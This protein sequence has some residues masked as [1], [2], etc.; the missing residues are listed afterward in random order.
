VSLKWE[1][2]PIRNLTISYWMN[3]MDPHLTQQPVFAYSAYAVDGRYGAGGAPHQTANEM[4][5]IHSPTYTRIFRATTNLNLV[6]DAVYNAAG[7]W[8]HN[9]LVWSSDP[10][11]AP[12]LI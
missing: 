10:T 12:L 5:V 11:G 2:S 8:Q 6:S 3:I 9:A 1:H 4:G 7:S